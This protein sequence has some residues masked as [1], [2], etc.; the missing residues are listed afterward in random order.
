MLADS[1]LTSTTVFLLHNTEIPNLLP[2]FIYN[3]KINTAVNC[4]TDKYL[5]VVAKSLIR[6]IN[7]I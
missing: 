3:F 2:D 4:K 1:I 7:L 6:N 5:L